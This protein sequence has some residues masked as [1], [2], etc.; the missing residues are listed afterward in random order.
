MIIDISEYSLITKRMTGQ[1]IKLFFKKSNE[2]SPTKVLAL[3]N[4]V[5]FIDN[6]FDRNLISIS[7]YDTAGSYGAD[8]SMQLKRP[9][10][11]NFMEVFIHTDKALTN[12]VFR[13]LS[14]NAVWRDFDN[15]VFGD[16]NY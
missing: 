15:A 7:I 2:K 6:C 9:E 12:S 11:E 13:S 10:V 14:E 8:M 16:K 4:V 3:T 5:A 1:N